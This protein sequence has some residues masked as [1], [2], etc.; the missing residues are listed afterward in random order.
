MADKVYN[1]LLLV[2]I[3]LKIEKIL[4]KNQNGFRRNRPKTSQN[5]CIHRIID[6]VC[7]KNLEAKILFVDFSKAFDSIHRRED[8]ENG[9]PPKKTFTAIIMLYKNMKEMVC[10]TMETQT[11]LTL[12][13]GDFARR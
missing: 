3:K 1:V 10:S 4:M 6:G 5:L 12:L 13:Q 11:S 7:A 2:R 8:G 9:L